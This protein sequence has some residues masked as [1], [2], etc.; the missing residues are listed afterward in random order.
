MLVWSRRS[1]PGSRFSVMRFW[2]DLTAT[3]LHTQREQSTSKT[4]PKKRRQKFMKTRNQLR[5]FPTG[6]QCLMFL[7]LWLRPCLSSREIIDLMWFS[8]MMFSTSGL[9][10]RT[11]YNTSRI[12]VIKMWKYINT[13]TL[14]AYVYIV[15]WESTL[16][17]NTPS[18]TISLQSFTSFT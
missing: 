9:S 13:I 11:Q 17:Y 4:W 6:K 5:F 12:P 16:Q 2:F 8:W 7:T 14:V 15:C 18:E 1:R 10:I 3:P